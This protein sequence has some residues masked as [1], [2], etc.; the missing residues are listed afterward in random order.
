GH[1]ACP[2]CG[3][4][5]GVE[6]FLRGIE[7]DVIMVNQT[8]CAYVV[9]ANYPT[10]AHKGN[11]MH[12]LFQNGASTLSGILEAILEQKRRGE[13]EFSDD[14]TFVMLSGDGGMDI[15][16]GPA[17][18]AALRNHKMI[19]LEYDNEGYMNTGAQL[20]Y[21]TPEGHRTSTSNIGKLSSGKNFDHKD[22]VQIMA[23]TNIPYVFTGV[24]AYPQDLVKKAAKAQWYANN[25]GLVYGKIL[26]SCPLNWKSE[27]KDG[28]VL[29]EK[30]VN[31]NFFPLYEIENGV[32]N[33][34]HNP[35]VLGSKVDAEEWLKLMGKSKHLLKPENK[36][37]LDHFKGI[38]NKRWKTLCAKDEHPNL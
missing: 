1:S 5:P 17:I 10:T 19:V 16:M 29:L 8:G 18:G 30:A 38:I 22:T 4:F 13:I 37:V 35:D 31:S 33:I 7:G 34:T 9:S 27:D 20:S 11:Y 21:S 2:G 28:S 6:M 23:A 15:G 24:D 25:H 12:N 32:T 3:I 36:E 26:I 14:A